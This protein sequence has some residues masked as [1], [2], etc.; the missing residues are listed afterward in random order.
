MFSIYPHSS[1]LMPNPFKKLRCGTDAFNGILRCI[2][3]DINS[4]LLGFPAATKD[5]N[6]TVSNFLVKESTGQANGFL[7][8]RIRIFNFVCSSFS[9]R[10]SYSRPIRKKNRSTLFP[11]LCQI[12]SQVLFSFGYF[13]LVHGNLLQGKNLKTIQKL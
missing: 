10:N 9:L 12:L 3:Y 11:K 8:P 6:G 7:F 5:S 4:T 1:W 13:C 2:L